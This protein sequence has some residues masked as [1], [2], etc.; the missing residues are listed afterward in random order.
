MLI[1]IAYF[2]PFRPSS[3]ALNLSTLSASHVMSVLTLIVSSLISGVPSLPQYAVLFVRPS[4]SD[5]AMY[6]RFSSYSAYSIL[7]GPFAKVITSFSDTG[8]DTISSEAVVAVDRNQV[9]PVLDPLVLFLLLV[10]N[11]EPELELRGSIRRTKVPVDEDEPERR[12]EKR[13]AIAERVKAGTTT[14]KQAQTMPTVGSTAVQM[15]TS[16]VL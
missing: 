2:Y 1:I 9:L 5:E 8:D 14:G 7:E 4:S 12:D 10:T 15:R 3:L 6:P 11:A 13:A 16:E